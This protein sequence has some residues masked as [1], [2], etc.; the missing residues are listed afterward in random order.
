MNLNILPQKSVVPGFESSGVW[1]MGGGS[2][3]WLF[4]CSAGG[5]PAHAHFYL[6]KKTILKGGCKSTANYL[7]PAFAGSQQ[8]VSVG[9]GMETLSKGHSISSALG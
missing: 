8:P 2:V 9:L 3:L 1:G 6:I 5:V 4:W 7:L